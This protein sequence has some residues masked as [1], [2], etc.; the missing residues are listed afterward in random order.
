M[1]RLLSCDSNNTM[2]CSVT[3]GFLLKLQQNKDTKQDSQDPLKHTINTI[4]AAQ[5]T[6]GH[7]G[8]RNI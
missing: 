7:Q 2:F 6:L 1:E 5:Y 8:P 4:Q 3:E